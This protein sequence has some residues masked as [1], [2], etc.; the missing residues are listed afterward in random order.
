MLVKSAVRAIMERTG[1]G[2]NALAKKIGKIPQTVSDRLNT[3]KGTNMSTDKLDELIRAMGYK[4]V[5]VPEDTK[6]KDGWY[7]VEDSRNVDG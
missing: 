4:I 2:N 7:E 6:V 5:L 3:E 1:T